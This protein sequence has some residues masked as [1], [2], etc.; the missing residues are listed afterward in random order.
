M[1]YILNMLVMQAHNI[2]KGMVLI[3]HA[4]MCYLEFCTSVEKMHVIVAILDPL[5]PC[6]ADLPLQQRD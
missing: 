1:R 5:L 3:W 4:W 6:S 2:M